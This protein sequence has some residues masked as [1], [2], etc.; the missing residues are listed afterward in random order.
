MLMVAN[1]TASA[2]QGHVEA[3]KNNIAVARE[4]LRS[5]TQLFGCGSYYQPLG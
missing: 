1:Q 4:S 2:D 3:A 5:V